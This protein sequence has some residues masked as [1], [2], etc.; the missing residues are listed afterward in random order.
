MGICD[1]NKRLKNHINNEGFTPQF[2]AIF[3]DNVNFDEKIPKQNDIASIKEESE[4]NNN[5]IP[6]TSKQ[7]E[8]IIKQSKIYICK[9]YFGKINGTGFLC[10]IP[11][12]DKN[13][14]LPVLITNNHVI[15]KEKLL[16][17]KKLEIAFD[18]DKIKK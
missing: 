13:N 18:D 4:K 17:D 14:C 5:K 2:N 16:K 9:I 8:K 12:P 1:N 11:F 7:S 3:N 10:K 15:E 6:I